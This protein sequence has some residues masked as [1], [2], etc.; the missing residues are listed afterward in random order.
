[1]RTKVLTVQWMNKKFNNYTFVLSVT[2]VHATPVSLTNA[3]ASLTD[4]LFK[5]REKWSAHIFSRARGSLLLLSPSAY[6]QLNKSAVDDCEKS[7]KRSSSARLKFE[8]HI[9]NEKAQTTEAICS[10]KKKIRAE[11]NICDLL[12]FVREDNVVL[13]AQNRGWIK[14]RKSFRKINQK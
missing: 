4:G 6:Q 2:T 3:Q 12:S 9:I 13:R 5:V 7:V 8:T 10:A 14:D 1:M 11:K